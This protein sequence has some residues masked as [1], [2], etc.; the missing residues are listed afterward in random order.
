MCVLVPNTLDTVY[1]CM[2]YMLHIYQ[3]TLSMMYMLHINQFT[4]SMMYMLHINQFIWYV[5]PSR[6]QIKTRTYPLKH[7]CRLRMYHDVDATH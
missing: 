1:L 7:V 3:L 5:P 6:E 4:L 2:M